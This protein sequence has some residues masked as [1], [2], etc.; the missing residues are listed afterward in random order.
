MPVHSAIQKLIIPTTITAGLRGHMTAYRS[1][2]V[3]SENAGLYPSVRSTFR[4]HGL[5]Y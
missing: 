2:H 4:F 1:P 3:T 5:G